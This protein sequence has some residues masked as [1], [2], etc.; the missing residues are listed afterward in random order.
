MKILSLFNEVF[1]FD[2]NEHEKIITFIVKNSDYNK[3]DLINMR[4]VDLIKLRNEINEKIVSYN[5]KYTIGSYVILTLKGLGG[6]PK[7][8]INGQI[9]K[10]DGRGW[11]DVKGSDGKIYF[12]NPK[13]NMNSHE[14]AKFRLI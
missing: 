6:R 7:R 3:N 2:S 14:V 1:G 12:I 11:I 4:L 5:E 8:E 9:I 13:L 10:H